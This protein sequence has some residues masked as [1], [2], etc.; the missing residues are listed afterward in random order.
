MLRTCRRNGV[1]GPQSTDCRC[2]H[3]CGRDRC[4]KISQS[5]CTDYMTYVSR[6]H[7]I[8]MCLSAM[9]YSL[10]GNGTSKPNDPRG[11]QHCYLIVDL[12][13]VCAT[14]HSSSVKKKKILSPGH[15][16]VLGRSNV[17]PG[18][19]EPYAGFQRTCSFGGFG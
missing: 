8:G 5:L 11:F 14:L 1:A 18:F 4:H 6:S 15:A 19:K 3:L 7:E 10:A 17:F 13:C 16:R 9:S 12:L 2:A